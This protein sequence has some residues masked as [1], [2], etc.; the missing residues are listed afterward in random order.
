MQMHVLV[1][2]QVHVQAQ[3]FLA[4]ITERVVHLE[5]QL[6]QRVALAET[7]ALHHLR[8]HHV[9]ALSEAKP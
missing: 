8:L 4:L 9:L 2:M 6:S 1:L 3:R 5:H 7:R